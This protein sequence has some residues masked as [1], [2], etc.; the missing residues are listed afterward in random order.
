LASC[1]DVDA[2]DRQPIESWLEDVISA[3]QT[4]NIETRVDY[5]SAL[6][7]DADDEDASVSGPTR[8]R[9]HSATLVV[10]LCSS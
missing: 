8:E 10:C 3:V 5:L 4:V 1:R 9:P 6:L 2:E 7:A